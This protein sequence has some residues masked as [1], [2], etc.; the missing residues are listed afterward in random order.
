[1][2][3]EI[4][5]LM[6]KLKL[7][8]MRAAYEGIVSTKNMQSI[9]NDELLNLLLQAE[10][11]ER[12]NLKANRRLL[13]AKF[14]MRA[15]MEEIDFFTPRGLNKTQLL[16]FTD[17]SFVRNGENVL[18]TGQ[19]GVG[20]SYIASAMGHMAC[21]LGYKVNYFIAQKLFT[22][23]RMSKADESYI[24]Q[25]KRIEKQDLII[26][27]DFGMQP[28]DEMTR[29]MLLEIIEDRHQKSS[30]IITSQL[31]VEKW[32]DVIGES[33][34]ADAILDRL[35]HTSHRVEISGESMRRKKKS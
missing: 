12:E 7:P 3:H 5:Q 10:W 20:K 1:M 18:I 28:L 25:V 27:D 30:T 9:G 31:P 11:D 34:V 33:T 4:Q 13:N 29:M 23:L 6:Q 14:R 24:K 17:G 15:S 8:G 26:I 19:T 2:T 32:Y 22:M 21:Q 16:R 35:V